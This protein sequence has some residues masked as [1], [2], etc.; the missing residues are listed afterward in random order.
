MSITERRTGYW[1]SLMGERAAKDF[2]KIHRRRIGDTKRGAEMREGQVGPVSG[3][4][5]YDDSPSA[6]ARGY[7]AAGVVAATKVPPEQTV[8][9]TLTDQIH[10]LETRLDGLRTLRSAL[11]FFSACDMSVS[12]VRDLAR[13]L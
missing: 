9:Q 2:L 4:K 11:T 10:E 12:K 1:L 5:G 6:E 8:Y 13:L 7:S 3:A